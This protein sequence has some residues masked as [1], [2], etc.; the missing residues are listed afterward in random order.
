MSSLFEQVSGKTKQEALQQKTEEIEII[1]SII[2][3]QHKTNP[4]IKCIHLQNISV[5][6]TRYF[7]NQGFIIKSYQR[8]EGCWY[9]DDWN[10]CS[11]ARCRD[12][13]TI[14]TYIVSWY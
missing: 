4:Q 10:P 12:P 11:C 14:I 9:G 13:E 5:Y 3:T 2:K 1:E 8:K 7:Q 6:A